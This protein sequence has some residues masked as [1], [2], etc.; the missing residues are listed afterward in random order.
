MSFWE[1]YQNRMKMILDGRKTNLN[2]E[3]G[4]KKQKLIEIDEE[5]EIENSEIPP[6]AVDLLNPQTKLTDWTVNEFMA[7]LQYK[8]FQNL[9]IEVLPRV[10][11]KSIIRNEKLDI[12][13]SSF[14]YSRVYV[15][16]IADFQACSTLIYPL[17]QK[18]DLT[19]CRS[20][21]FPINISNSHWVCVIARNGVL[22][23]YDSFISYPLVEHEILDRVAAICDHLSI[24]VHT[25]IVYPHQHPQT[26]TTS[27]GV[28]VCFRASMM[29]YDTLNQELESPDDFRKSI[30]D[31]IF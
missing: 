5:M 10:Q 14:L 24:P 22:T 11:V 4:E 31:V 2:V 25:K 20:L 26:D 9:G 12:I 3:S 13:F 8:I 30:V 1:N 15:T 23:L 18:V 16:P 28:Y 7:K 21:F 17:Y 29:M 6:A 27:C 19:L